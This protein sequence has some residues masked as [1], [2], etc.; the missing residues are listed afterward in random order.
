MT[1]D[2]IHEGII[3]VSLYCDSDTSDKTAGYYLDNKYAKLVKK[4]NLKPGERVQYKLIDGE[5]EILSKIHVNKKVG[6]ALFVNHLRLILIKYPKMPLL[7][8]LT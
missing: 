8:F 1:K 6:S 3:R 2:E 7:K 5:P 4:Y